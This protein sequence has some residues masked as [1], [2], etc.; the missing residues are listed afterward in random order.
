MTNILDHEFTEEKFEYYREFINKEQALDFVE[1]LDQHSILYSL[2]VPQVLIDEAIVGT[3]MLPKVILK[4][5]PRDFPRL[6]QLLKETIEKQVIP[7]DYYLRDFTD[8]ELFTLIE[9]PDNWSIED[10][11]RA[12]KILNERGYDLS[13][14]QIEKIIDQR[15][16]EL[17]KGKKANLSWIVFY[18]VCSLLGILFLHPLFLFAG[19]G[20]GIYY[21]QDT[22]TDPNG[23]LYYTYDKRSRNAG[24]LIFVASLVFLSVWLF[25]LLD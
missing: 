13:K 2:E 8:L 7:E 21:W 17:K 24:Q 10:H 22:Q 25:T 3:G 11:T 19:L 15:Y 6:N 5:L 1:L 9:E 16:S 18:L 14:Q 23:Q 4:I 12:K 20:M